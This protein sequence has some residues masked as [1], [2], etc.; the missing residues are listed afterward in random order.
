VISAL[1]LAPDPQKAA[2][3]LRAVIDSVLKRRGRP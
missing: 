3:D 1:S 2:Q